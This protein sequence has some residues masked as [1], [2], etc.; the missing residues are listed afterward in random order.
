VRQIREEDIP[1]LID[2][3]NRRY[4]L[5]CE[6]EATENWVRNIVL[7]SPIIF[8]AARTD[9]A[10]LICILSCVPWYPAEFECNVIFVCA[11]EGCLWEAV[12]L[13]RCSI[14]WARG[15]R[16][17]WWKMSGDTEYDMTPLAR[18]LGA[19]DLAPRCFLRL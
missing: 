9:N 11:E 7:K 16:C 1:W 6:R 2:L 19:R 17:K 13:L 5:P 14:A 3:G 4:P 10:F 15:R 8:Y 12:R 18:R